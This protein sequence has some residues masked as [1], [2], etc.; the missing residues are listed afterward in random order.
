MSTRLLSPFFIA[1]FNSVFSVSRIELA[2]VDMES[3]PVDMPASESRPDICA[4]TAKATHC[5][6]NGKNKLVS[7]V[8]AV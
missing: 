2:P 5:N 3:A 1:A 7:T 6:G 4:I 8:R